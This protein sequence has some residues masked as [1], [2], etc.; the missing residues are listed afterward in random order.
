MLADITPEHDSK[1]QQLIA[2]LR[3]KFTN[4]INEGNKK[5]IIFTAFSD[6]AGYLYDCLAEQIK[7]KHGLHT[8]LVSGDVEARSTLRLP[9]REK[10]DFNKGFDIVFSYFQR[11]GN[12]LSTYTRRNRCSNCHRLYFRR[13]E[14]T[15][16]R[17]SHQLRYTLKSRSHH[18][19]LRTY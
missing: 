11:E 12:H 3:H 15:G 5:V 2:D 18:P 14:P 7:A 9:Q 6:T 13:S 16:L 17:L 1:L 4:P 10:L 19:T 8:A